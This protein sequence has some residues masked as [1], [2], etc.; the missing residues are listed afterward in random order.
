VHTIVIYSQNFRWIHLAVSPASKNVFTY[1]V[2]LKQNN[3]DNIRL[4]DIIII[5]I[6]TLLSLKPNNIKLMVFIQQTHYLLHS[7]YTLFV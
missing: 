2:C 1:F 6:I 3:K 4:L 7:I 5:I